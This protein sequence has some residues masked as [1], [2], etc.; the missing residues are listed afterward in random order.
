MT[1]EERYKKMR[2]LIL[3]YEVSNGWLMVLAWIPHLPMWVCEA[4]ASYYVWKSDRKERK[5][6][7]EHVEEFLKEP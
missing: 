1:L 7:Q 5:M 6:F 2:L 4:I 3:Y